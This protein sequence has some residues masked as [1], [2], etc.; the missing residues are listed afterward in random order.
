MYTLIKCISYVCVCVYIHLILLYTF[1]P[2]S[3]LYFQE[4]R[5]SWLFQ[6]WGLPSPDL[7]SIP[8]ARSPAEWAYLY[9]CPEGSRKSFLLLFFVNWEEL[10]LSTL[11]RREETQKATL[12]QTH[13]V[14]PLKYMVLL[15]IF[16]KC[17]FFTSVLPQI[18]HSPSPLPLPPAL[19]KM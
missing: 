19:W 11:K 3:F 8:W 17:S 9:C 18:I 16:F 2:L 10:R 13:K 5:C 7:Q 14:R 6:L 4:G 12:K 1:C 15:Q